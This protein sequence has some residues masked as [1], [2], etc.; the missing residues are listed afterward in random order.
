[1]AKEFFDYDPLTGVTHYTEQV[2]E[3]TILH[4]EQDLTPLIERNKKIANSGQRDIGIKEGWW[5][6]CDIPPVVELK[7]KQMGINIHDPND[8]KKMFEVINRDFPALKVTHKHHA[9]RTVK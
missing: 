1:M 6:Y 9:E 3:T 5:H 2:N 4:M 7:L 8:G